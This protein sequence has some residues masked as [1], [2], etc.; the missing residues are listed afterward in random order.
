[1]R[2]LKVEGTTDNEFDQACAEV[3]QPYVQREL[4]VTVS[5]QPQVRADGAIERAEP[6]V[7]TTSVVT[8]GRELQE[9]AR[10]YSK[11]LEEYKAGHP[12]FAQYGDPN[13]PISIAV[14]DEI[15]RM[16]NG[17]EITEFL[18]F[19]PDVCEALNKLHPLVAAR[20][21][22]EISDDLDWGRVPEERVDFATWRDERNRQEASRPHKPRKR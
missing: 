20:R 10:A 22:Q 17:V 6:T 13:A 2:R 4:T 19:C 9:N 14:R 5:A 18:A 11:R 8:P 7:E 16:P 1:M 21:V 3:L 15:L 12:Q